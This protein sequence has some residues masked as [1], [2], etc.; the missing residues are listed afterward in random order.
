MENDKLVKASDVKEYLKRV[1][2]GADQKIDTWV[3]SI[4][5]VDAVEVCRCKDCR[6]G[7]IDQYSAGEYVVVCDAPKKRPGTDVYALDWYCPMGQRREDD[8]A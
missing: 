7:T 1:I 4:P 3:D 6:Y 8:N 5:A 2:F